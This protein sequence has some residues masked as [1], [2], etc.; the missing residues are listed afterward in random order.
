M[1]ARMLSLQIWS[2]IRVPFFLFDQSFRIGAVTVFWF[3]IGLFLSVIPFIRLSDTSII[4]ELCPFPPNKHGRTFFRSS[5]SYRIRTGGG[6]RILF[7][8][9]RLNTYAARAAFH[10]CPAN[11]HHCPSSNSYFRCDFF[12][13]RGLK[14]VRVVSF[15]STILKEKKGKK[16]I[17]TIQNHTIF[18]LSL[19]ITTDNKMVRR[20]TSLD[21]TPIWKPLLQR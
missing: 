1:I 3:S 13:F 4:N 10:F 18:S 20:D 21:P 6:G 7:Y 2:S 9:T 11:P 8:P 15:I 19:S 17:S 14:I 5:Q 16:V 12:C